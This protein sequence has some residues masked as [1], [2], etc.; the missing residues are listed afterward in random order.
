M[1]SDMMNKVLVIPN[2]VKDK[3]F[4]MT[5]R[6]LRW[7]EEHGISTVLPK[8]H[9]GKQALLGYTFCDVNELEGVDF[10]LVLGGDGTIIS[11]SR[12]YAS[13]QLPL[14]GINLGNLGFLAEIEVRDME[15]ALLSVIK[16]NYVIEERLMV[17]AEHDNGEFIG[18]ALNDIVLTRQSI[19]RMISF[20]V[21]VNRQFVNQYRADGVIISTPT[22]STAYNLSAGGPIITP[23]NDVIV[24]TPICPHSLTAR[25][26]ILNGDDEIMIVFDHPRNEHVDDLLITVDGQ[27]VTEFAKS[28]PIHIKRSNDKVKLIRLQYN[29]FF[30][31]LRG[32]LS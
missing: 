17:Q 14:L 10:G 7:L 32:K 27:E 3:D 6:V 18:T 16:G 19:S 29:D 12:I 20:D 11:T 1:G 8:E 31:I 13:H 9:E 23:T 4:H 2:E 5:L 22:G 25:S 15:E 30:K 28:D 24:F 26:M 21:Y